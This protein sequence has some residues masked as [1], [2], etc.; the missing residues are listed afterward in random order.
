MRALQNATGKTSAELD[1]MMKQGK[2][3]SEYIKPLI[4]EIGKL[5][6]ANG[7]Y[8][9]ALKK[10]GT[11]ENQLKASGG[12]AAARIAEAGF[13]EGLIKLYS[14]LMGAMEDNGTTLDRL[15]NIYN[16]VFTGLAALVRMVTPLFESFV[17]VLNTV[18]EHPF[19]PSIALITAGLWAAAKA[20][21]GF[22]L[23]L[24]AALRGPM[25]VISAFLGL[26]QEAMAIFD[27]DLIGIGENAK[28][29]KEDRD[30]AAAH[31]AQSAGRATD[32]DKKLLAGLPSGRITEAVNN[33]GGLGSLMYSNNF[34]QKQK[35][36]GQSVNDA[37]RSLQNSISAP[38]RWIGSQIFH[39][40]V[41]SPDPEQAGV[42]VRKEFDNRLDLAMAPSK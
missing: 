35:D 36:I 21:G 41:S 32:A 18:V 3:T 33:S 26:V 40:T 34:I 23:A 28:A 12:Y 17:A 4:D 38:G 13:T 1:E 7:A 20:A 37:S 9:K 14:E 42:M 22:G 15:G 29:S 27:A 5:A 10:L 16:K 2:L 11:V 25:V 30:I 19:I 39:I 8:E 31:F 24:K 6:L